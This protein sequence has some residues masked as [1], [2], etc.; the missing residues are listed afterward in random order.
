MARVPRRQCLFEGALFHV[1]WQCHNKDFLLKESWVKKLLYDLLLKYKKKYSMTIFS[2]IIMDNH[3]HL[4]GMVNDLKKFSK[5]FQVVHSVFAKEINKQQKRCG[6]VIRDRF[7]SPLLQNEDELCKEM[8]YHDLNEVRCGKSND[9][10]ENEFSSYFHYAHGRP[11]PLLTDPPFYKTLGRTPQERQK[12]Y[13]ALVL[14]ILVAAPRKKNGEYTQKLFIGDPIWV[15]EK[16][17]ELKEIRKKL[18]EEIMPPGKDPP[19][20]E[21]KSPTD[22]LVRKQKNS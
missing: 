19:K 2:Y 11:D 1:T 15:E 4:S 13:R 21:P 6:Q 9:P 22:S 17:K 20:P 12:A 18:R 7:K 10:N 16:Y 14:E 8:T 5:Y 3:L